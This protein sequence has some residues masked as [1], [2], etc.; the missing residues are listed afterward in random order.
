M[1]Q[2]GCAASACRTKLL[3]M[4]PAP[5]V[6]RTSTIFPAPVV[7]ERPVGLEPELVRLIV[8]V[9]L[10]RRVHHERHRVADALP[11]VVHQVRHLDEHGILRS[12]SLIHISEPTRLGM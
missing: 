8:P 11:P 10:G 12:L 7:G 5:P 3:P 4:N 9:W 1:R 6:T 2:S